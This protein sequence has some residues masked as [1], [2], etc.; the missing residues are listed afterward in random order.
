MIGKIIESK[1][2]KTVY[3][4]YLYMSKHTLLKMYY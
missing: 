2:I 1:I 4:I 3:P